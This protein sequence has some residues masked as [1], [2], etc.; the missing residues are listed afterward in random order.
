M[1]GLLKNFDHFRHIPKIP[2]YFQKVFSVSIFGKSFGS[3][4]NTFAKVESEIKTIQF[5][6]IFD[7]RNNSAFDF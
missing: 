7:R 3:F 6:T 5:W 1:D 2:V 4:G